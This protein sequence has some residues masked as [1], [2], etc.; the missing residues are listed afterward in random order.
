MSHYPKHIYS[1]NI[2]IT[3]ANMRE[4][5]MRQERIYRKCL[6][7]RPDYHKIGLREQMKVRQQAADILG[8]TL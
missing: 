3:R 1:P 7:L 6:E 8:Y 4:Y 5:D 2:Q